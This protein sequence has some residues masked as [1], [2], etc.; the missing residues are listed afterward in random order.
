[1]KPLTLDPGRIDL[2]DERYRTSPPGP[3]D[4]LVASIRAVGLLHPPLVSRE[5]ERRVIVSGWKRVLA[6]RMMGLSP[7]EVMDTEEPDGLKNF[8]L[9]FLDNLAARP[10]G[11]VEKAEAL[12]RLAAFGESRE[13]ILRDTMPLLDLARNADLLQAHIDIAGFEPEIKK[14]IEEQALPLAV[15][16]GLI[17]FIREDRAAIFPHL[18]PLGRNKQKEV[19]ENLQEIC[20]RDGRAAVE[21][22]SLDPFRA[23]GLKE[24]LSPLQ[25][26]ELLR[27]ELFRMRY[28]AYSRQREGFEEAR[29]GLDLPPEVGLE[30]APFFEKNEV[31]VSFR[32]KSPAEL[33]SI[34]V[35]LGNLASDEHL[36]KIFYWM[37]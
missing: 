11:L 37:D 31:N 22:L 34:L 6:S 25:K 26:S 24:Q 30:P 28:P 17:P 15:A 27:R 7:I 16:R 10:M 20:R 12:S 4:K 36:K 18:L 3:L 1:M 5:G 14:G 23:I 9:G 29:R 19:L 33:R 2:S 21:V 35:R 32:V 13:A 8:L